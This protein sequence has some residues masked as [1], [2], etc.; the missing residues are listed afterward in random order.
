[1]AACWGVLSILPGTPYASDNY[2]WFLERYESFLYVD[3]IVVSP[4]ARGQ[5]IGRQLYLDLVSWGRGRVSRVT[6]EVNRRPSNP[7]SVLFHERMG[8][9]VVGVHETGNGSKEV[10]LMS[11]ELSC[12]VVP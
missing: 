3:R 11:R 5:G 6:C 10:Q 7:G 4:E 2:R 9:V 8:F 12:G 1:M